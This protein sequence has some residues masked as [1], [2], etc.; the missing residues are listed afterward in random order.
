M[1]RNV[2]GELDVHLG[3]AVHPLDPL[4]VPAF[5]RAHDVEENLCIFRR[6]LHPHAAVAVGA[7]IMREQVLVRRVV[8]VD[9][10]AVGEV[11]PHPTERVVVARR[12]RDV[13]CAVAIVFDRTLKST[14]RR[15]H[16]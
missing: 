1:H 3:A 11:E 15:S 9:Q 2:G 12:L 10:E 7:R 14:R 8:L 6:V 4:D 5:G 16:A 13:H